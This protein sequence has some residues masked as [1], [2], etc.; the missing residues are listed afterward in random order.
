MKYRIYGVKNAT[1]RKE[2]RNAL[3]YFEQQLCLFDFEQ[4]IVKVIVTNKIDVYGYCSIE[5]YDDQDNVCELVMEVQTGQSND[6]I[7][8]T[9]AHEMVHIR[10]YVRGHLN[11]DMTRWKGK[12]IDSESIDYDD[13]PWEIE[14]EKLGDVLYELWDKL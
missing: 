6:E 10:Q 8:H 14:A 9:L 5:S 11:E 1:F 2:M 12:E 3:Q 13:H 7:I 4:V